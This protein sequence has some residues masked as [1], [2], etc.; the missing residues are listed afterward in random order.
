MYVNNDFITF[1]FPCKPIC[2]PYMYCTK[3]G[4]YDQ[5]HNNPL[6]CRQLEESTLFG[7][8][9]FGSKNTVVTE[10]QRMS[11]RILSSSGFS[12][13][14]MPHLVITISRSRSFSSRAHSC[15]TCSVQRTTSHILATVATPQRSM[16]GR[17]VVTLE[18]K[19]LSKVHNPEMGP[20]KR[21]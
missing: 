9:P 6:V 19:H 21:V 10:S 12:P 1:M 5:P 4:S 7:F 15:S 14:A 20:N 18:V 3:D 11:L 13:A 8:V 17:I 2:H 16:H